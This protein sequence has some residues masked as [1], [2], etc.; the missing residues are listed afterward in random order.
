MALNNLSPLPTLYENATNPQIIY[1]RVSNNIRPDELT[2][3]T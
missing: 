3:K 1:A 2:N